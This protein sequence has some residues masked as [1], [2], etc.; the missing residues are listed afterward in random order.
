MVLRLQL[1]EALEKKLLDRARASG[2]EAEHYAHRLLEREL[3]AP[4]LDEVLA[5]FRKQVEDSG[6]SDD[7]L[8]ELVE[9]AREARY[10][11]RR[12]NNP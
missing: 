3:T 5:P 7:E 12:S 11:E 1:S 2:E 10:Q 9:Q 8:D 6:I 4:S